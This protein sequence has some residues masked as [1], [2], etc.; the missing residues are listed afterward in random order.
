[1]DKVCSRA[2]AGGVTANARREPAEFIQLLLDNT[3]F[4][5]FPVVVDRVSNPTLRGLVRRDQLLQLLKADLALP[6]PLLDIGAVRT[7]RRIPSLCACC[8][9]SGAHCD[10]PAPCAPPM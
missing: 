10:L 5:G 6:A 2:R 3:P 8:L 1:M 7:S 9:C 4:N